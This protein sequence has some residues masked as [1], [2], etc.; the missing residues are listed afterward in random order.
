MKREALSKMEL[1]EEQINSIMETNGHDIENAK[2]SVGD[3]EALKTENETLKGNVADRD[4]DLKALKKQ[5]GDNEELTKQATDLQAKY[6]ED[7]KSLTAQLNQTKLD[8]GYC[9]ELRH[10]TLKAVKGLLDMDKIKLTEDGKLD[11]V[12]D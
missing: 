8:G 7:T 12:D 2:K 9:L 5:L 11:G 6:D 3:V 4:K 1:T 10:V